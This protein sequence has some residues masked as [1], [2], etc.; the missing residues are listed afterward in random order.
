MEDMQDAP[1]AVVQVAE[2]RSLKRN[3][4]RRQPDADD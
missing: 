4:S 1:A 2:A 3:E